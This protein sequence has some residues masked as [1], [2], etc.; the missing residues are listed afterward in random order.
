MDADADIVCNYTM[1]RL[2]LARFIRV[3]AEEVREIL[4]SRCFPNLSL[5]V[6][7]VVVATTAAAATLAAAAAGVAVAAAAV[8][9]T[10]AAVG[11]VSGK[12][13]V[14]ACSDAV[15]RQYSPSW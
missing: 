7:E 5:F 6:S 14:E 15:G 1:S 2:E 4:E 13:V 10:M 12:E 3:P 8:V 9:A 11:R